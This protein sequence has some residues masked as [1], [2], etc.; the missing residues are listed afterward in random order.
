MISSQL[1]ACVESEAK[2]V[3]SATGLIEPVA[4]PVEA[5]PAGETTL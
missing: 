2:Q 1:A 5:I 4:E 3:E